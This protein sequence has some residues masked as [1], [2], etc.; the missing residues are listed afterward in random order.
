MKLEVILLRII[1]MIFIY[2]FVKIAENLSRIIFDILPL[3]YM[4]ISILR[5]KR[6]YR[7]LSKIIDEILMRKVVFFSWK[8]SPYSVGVTVVFL[9][10][11]MM[12]FSCI[13]GCIS[14]F[15][16]VGIPLLKVIAFSLKSYFF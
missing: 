13:V 15:L 8:F 5:Y 9:Y 11:I 6:F 14:W 4:R 1:L 12:L 10:G 3:F 16:L 2:I 7:I